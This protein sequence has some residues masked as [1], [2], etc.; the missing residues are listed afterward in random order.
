MKSVDRAEVVSGRLIQGRG[1]RAEER[2]R[3]ERPPDGL[4]GRVRGVAPGSIPGV[5]RRNAESIPGV[6]FSLGEIGKNVYEA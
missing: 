5:H 6:H 2:H 3:H 1:G 4:T